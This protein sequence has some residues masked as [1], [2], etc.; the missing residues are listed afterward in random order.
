MLIIPGHN[1]QHSQLRVVDGATTNYNAPQIYRSVSTSCF[2][3]TFIPNSFQNY[4]IGRCFAFCFTL[5]N[6]DVFRIHFW[7]LQ[8]SKII[9]LRWGNLWNIATLCCI[10]DASLTLFSECAVS[11]LSLMFLTQESSQLLS[12]TSVEVYNVLS[13]FLLFA[14]NVIKLFLLCN[15][16]YWGNSNV[17]KYPRKSARSHSDGQSTFKHWLFRTCSKVFFF[18]KSKIILSIGAIKTFPLTNTV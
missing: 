2:S 10:L 3:F 11:L 17:C 6:Q 14:R 5:T 8:Q 12:Y 9:C 18:H 15:R 1:N 16:I 13:N 4:S 7:C